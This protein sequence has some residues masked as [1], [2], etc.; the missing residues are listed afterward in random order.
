MR[1]I[2]ISTGLTLRSYLVFLV[3]IAGFIALAARVFCL[4]TIN[5]D[6][7]QKKVVDQLTT[8]STISSERGSIYDASGEVLAT[9]V[10]SYR[11]FISPSSIQKAMQNGREGLDESEGDQPTPVMPINVQ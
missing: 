8:E 7:Y 4:Q 9:N 10:T 5:F 3:I 2:K 1:R 6:Y 11:I